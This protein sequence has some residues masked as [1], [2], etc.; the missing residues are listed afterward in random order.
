MG[1]VGWTEHERAVERLRA[2]YAAI[3]AGAPVRLAKRTSN[4]MAATVPIAPSCTFDA[5]TGGITAVQV[6]NACDV[7][8][9]RSIEDCAVGATPHHPM[10]DV[11]GEA[12]IRRLNATSVRV[13]RNDPLGN[14]PVPGLFA[15]Y[16]IC[17]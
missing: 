17:S 13:T 16:A 3:P 6:G 12:T 7:T 14:G 15:I 4:V 8:F 2:S 11:G 1:L 9:P 5:N 10:E